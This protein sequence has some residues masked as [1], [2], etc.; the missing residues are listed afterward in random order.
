MSPQTVSKLLLVFQN[1]C[2]ASCSFDG[3]VKIW[4]HKGVEITTIRAHQQRVNDCDL[5]ISLASTSS[6]KFY[7]I[8]HPTLAIYMYLA[9]HF[10]L[11]PVVCYYRT[12]LHC[13]I[14]NWNQLYHKARARHLPLL[15]CRGA[16]SVVSTFCSVCNEYIVLPVCTA[17]VRFERLQPVS[18][19]SQTCSL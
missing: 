15:Y 12:T 5:H 9:I 11:S 1:G 6:S 16:L 3:E 8:M 17:V 14:F 18:H 19:G 4:S 7:V 13:L 2:I 10:C